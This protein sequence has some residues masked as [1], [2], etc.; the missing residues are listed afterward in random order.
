M[1]MGIKIRKYKVSIFGLATIVGFSFILVS[2][3]LLGKSTSIENKHEKRSIKK[4]VSSLTKKGPEISERI[5]LINFNNLPL[6]FESNQGQ[7][8]SKVKF[9]SRGRGYSFFLTPSE[10][11]L[12]LSKPS[13]EETS[14]DDNSKSK[15]V[16]TTQT[17][18]TVVR[19]KLFGANQEPSIIGV[20]ELPGKVNYFIGND[21]TK[22][23]TNIP[24]YAKVKYQAVYPG[25][26]LVYYGNQRQLEYD[27]IVAP[28]TDPSTITLG[29]EGADTLEVDVRG[30]L[31]LHTASGE[32]RQHKPVV[33]QE[34][35]GI[36]QE[37]S[38]SYLLKGERKVGFQVTAYDVSKPLIIDPVLSYSTYLGGSSLD[39]NFNVEVDDDGNAYVTGP[40]SS[41]TDF[42]TTVG[43]FQTAFAGGS[44]PLDIYVTKLNSSGS[45]LVYS[46]YLG[47]SGNEGLGGGQMA[48]DSAG[49]AYV[50]G[51]TTSTNYPTT[52][53]AFQ[54]DFAGGG[55]GGNDAFVTKLNSTGSDLVYSTYLGG[56]DDDGGLDIAVDATDN[57][58]VIGSTRSDNFPTTTGALRTS[59]GGDQDS[60]V[61]KLNAAG[62]ALVYS[63]YLGGGSSIDGGFSLAVDSTGNAYATGVTTT[64]FPTTAGAFDTSF[65]GDLDGYVTKLNSSGSALVYSTYLGGSS[66]DVGA[67]IALDDDGNAHVIGSTSSTNFPTATP[68]QDTIG[69]GQDAYVTKLNATGS[70]LVYSTYL[71]GSGGDSGFDIA[72]DDDDVYVTGSTI[73]TNFP[74]TLGAFQT[75][76][77]GGN[78]DAFVAKIALI[79][80]DDDDE[81]EE[82]DD[83]DDD[84]DDGEWEDD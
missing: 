66:V 49:N 65:N 68:L 79:D 76:F 48:I 44:F 33:Y 62:T 5:V 54:T 38:G 57:A 23:R 82:E 20:D 21:K 10:A 7:T 45:A 61:T 43:A 42:P 26:D 60:F 18:N 13:G 69:G 22:W 19:M 77:G 51:D 56:R 14:A 24:T 75:T 32:V 67:G 53:G 64:D 36:R 15:T 25:V 39:Q 11:V 58:Y 37:I 52:P 3:L 17:E 1:K 28:G 63:T 81:D 70:A 30:D 6:R 80:D 71:G 74:T 83:D 41:S 50:T 73:S 84:D 78:G 9:L 31:V 12:V 27:F 47:G 8:D 72:V 16:M 55:G 29:F 40:T 46:T 2:M 59:L 34:V 35:D 4:L